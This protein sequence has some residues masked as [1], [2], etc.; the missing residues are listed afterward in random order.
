LQE[1]LESLLQA[2][3]SERRINY[4]LER[5]KKALKELGNPERN[6]YS[7]II[8]GTNGKGSTTLFI[9]AAL[10]EAGKK[11]CTFLSP[12]LQTV[13]ERFL[14]GMEPADEREILAI[15]RELSAVGMKYSLSYFEFLTLLFFVW[16]NHRRADC[17]VLEVGLG[18][19]LDATNVTTPAA[20]ALTNVDYDHQAYLGN[21]LSE[22]L[23][24]KLG[25]VPQRGNLFTSIET[26]PLIA[27]VTDYC[28][29]NDSRVEFVHTSPEHRSDISA[30]GQTVNV[31]G[32]NS[33][34]IINPTPG[35]A[36][37]A[38]LSMAL[39]RQTFPEISFD[40]LKKG[41]ERVRTPGRMEL[42]CDSPQIFL[43]GD[44]NPAGLECLIESLSELSIHRPRVVCA[45][46]PDKPFTSMIKRLREISHS[47]LLTQVSRLS[48]A[49]SEEY[50]RSAEFEPDPFKAIKIQSQALDERQALVITGSL[51][52]VGE[53]RTLWRSKVRF[54]VDPNTV[55]QPTFQSG[56]RPK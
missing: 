1:D 52:L 47:L 54:L 9:S 18:G 40:I 46:S 21:T 11:V 35:A 22:I 42:V 24:E 4:D 51:Y 10:H 6:V 55:F 29:T 13:T 28:R 2:F 27:Q 50:R 56:D 34:R 39:L 36:K 20:C 44:H 19:R 8:S 14:F 53:V 33:I 45:F 48:S 38:R 12:H 3:G 7:L 37:N 49:T 23:N 32:G 5:F 17:L 25:V 43:S 26:A 15:A 31:D 30:L 16:A 41:L